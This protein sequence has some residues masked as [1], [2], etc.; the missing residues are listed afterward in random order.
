MTE[1]DGSG[2]GEMGEYSGPGIG[3]IGFAVP[4]RVEVREP[5]WESHHGDG[6]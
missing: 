1:A 6:G 4:C 5:G 2:E 3:Q